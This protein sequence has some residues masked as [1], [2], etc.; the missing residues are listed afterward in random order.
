MSGSVINSIP[1]SAFVGVAP[2]VLSAGGQALDLSGL[3]LTK[4]TR[5][6]IGSV[7]SF[8]SALEVGNYFG[9]NS[10]EY[11]AAIVYFN[12]FDSADLSPAALLMAQ[13]PAAAVGAYLRGGNVSSMALATLQSQN[14]TINVTIDGVLQTAV[15]NF[16]SGVNSFSDAAQAISTALAINGAT[17]AAFTGF[18]GGAATGTGA[19]TNLTVSSVT[20]FIDIGSTVTGTG[21]PASTTIISQTSGSTGGAGVYVT[22]QATTASSAALTFTSNVLHV[23][24]KTSGSLAI[25]QEVVGAGVANGT[26]ITSIT[27]GGGVGVYTT[28]AAPVHIVSESMTTALPIVTFDSISGGFIINSGTTGT[29]STMSYG[30]SPSV[31]VAAALGLTQATGAILSQ[32]AAQTTPAAFMSQV[33]QQT[34]D[35]ASLVTLFDPDGSGNS[36]KLAFASWI[37]GQND[38]Y[39]YFCWDT[40]ITPTQGTAATTSLGYLVTANEYSGTVPIYEPAGTNLHLAAFASG[41]VAAIDFNEHEGRITLAYKSQTGIIPS[42]YDQTTMDNLISNGYNFYGAVATANQRFQFFYPGSISGPFQWIDSYVN[43]IWLTNQLQLAMMEML[44]SYKSIPYNPAGSGIVRAAA[45]DPINQALDFGAIRAGVTLSSAQANNVNN[46]AGLKID[47]TLSAQGYY[48]LIG[49][50]PPQ[51]RQARKSPPLKLWYMDGESIQNI[52]ISSITVQ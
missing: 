36:Q 26:F 47:A 30:S 34:Q 23:T 31:A 35:W 29:A 46:S 24:A 44:T 11:N 43:Q 1:A 10:A 22:S 27:A 45:Q 16:S 28:T 9:F 33:I 50:A 41:M 19:S 12:G 21:V 8:P 52:Q 40:D 51:V 15:V 13:Y 7:L 2:S 17:A 14:G 5:V 20:G 18:F 25:G 39:L 49:T 42:V 6:P 37:N 3:F 48:L 38:R 32:G 4:N